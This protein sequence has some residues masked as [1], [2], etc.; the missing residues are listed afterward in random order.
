MY[1]PLD[2]TLIEARA[3]ALLLSVNHLVLV[4]KSVC[5]VPR[6]LDWVDECLSVVDDHAETLRAAAMAE[7]L[8]P[9]S[10][11]TPGSERAMLGSHR[12]TNCSDTEHL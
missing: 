7:E 4:A 2:A 11:S 9:S 12:T 3:T 5:H 8:E 6:A 1:L 10:P